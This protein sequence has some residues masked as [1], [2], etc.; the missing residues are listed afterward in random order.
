[1]GRELNWTFIR[2]V[3]AYRREDR[4]MKAR[5]YRRHETDWEIHRGGRQE[6]RI[7]DAVISQCG[8]YVWT[9]LG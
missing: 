5:G 7:I 9:K 1:M 6:E 3:L 2:R 4:K 8:K